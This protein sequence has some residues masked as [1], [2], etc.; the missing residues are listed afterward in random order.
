MKAHLL[1]ILIC[2]CLF[3]T[4]QDEKH[5][6]SA[7]ILIYDASGSMWGQIDGA[8]KNEIA[9]AVVTATVANLPQDQKI[10]LVAYG[11]RSKGD[12][13]DVEFLAPTNNTDKS[14]ISASLKAIKPL[15]KTPLAY[16]ATL[17]IDKLK[18]D[19]SKATIILLTDGIESCDGNLCEVVRKAKEAGIE[20]KLHIIG[21]GL[22]DGATESLLCAAKEGEGEYFD[23]ADA[24]SLGAMLQRATSATVDIPNG[25][26]TVFAIKNGKPIDAYIRAFPKSR[27]E[28]E[29]AA[30]T[31]AD[32]AHIYLAPGEWD[33]EVKPLEQSDVKATTLTNV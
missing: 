33:I 6:S 20:F 11:H 4:A 23:A 19:K 24:S 12:C 28:K 10:G 22:E 32:T 29:V 31:Y 13:K 2:F 5:E 25:N 8:S 21:F 27:D 18:A 3:L 17:V 14:K 26:F 15:G 9:S 7:L 1:L 30:R 16:S